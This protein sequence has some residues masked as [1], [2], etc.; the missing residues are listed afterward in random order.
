MQI[1][2]KTKEIHHAIS[3]IHIHIFESRQG[4][5]VFVIKGK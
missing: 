4:N 2:S 1:K 5:F 3:Y